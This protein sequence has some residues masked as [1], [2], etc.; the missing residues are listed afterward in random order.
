MGET[1]DA[2]AGE[3]RGEGSAIRERGWSRRERIE[4]HRKKSFDRRARSLSAD[5]DRGRRVDENLGKHRSR[6]SSRPLARSPRGA[7]N[8][9]SRQISRVRGIP[10]RRLRGRRKGRARWRPLRSR[11]VHPP[12]PARGAIAVSA[13][14]TA[15]QI[16]SRPPRASSHQP[17]RAARPQPKDPPPPTVPLPPS[18]VVCHPVGYDDNAA[19]GSSGKLR[20]PLSNFQPYKLVKL[21]PDGTRR[22]LTNAEMKEFEKSH[23]SQCEWNKPLTACTRQWQKQCLN[24]LKKMM[25]QKKLSWAF[26]EP[27]DPVALGIPDYPAI[28]KHPMDLRTIEDA[29]ARRDLHPG[30]VHRPVPHGV[31]QR[32]R[33][34]QAGPAG[35]REGVRGA[36]QPGVREG[37]RQDVRRAPASASEGEDVTTRETGRGEAKG[38]A[39]GAARGVRSPEKMRRERQP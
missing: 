35:R 6:R 28:I 29:H 13:R 4:S 20:R 38:T 31:P 17:C 11:D 7:K 30:R 10:A 22:P 12:R 9:E 26:N 19:D 27:V 8:A 18:A 23:S 15:L 37:D 2:H 33:V 14:A 3:A 24:L 25:T 32:V 36:T 21:E 1:R 5:F 34:Q 16:S 39:E